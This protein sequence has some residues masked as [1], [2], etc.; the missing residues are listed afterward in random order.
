MEQKGTKRHKKGEGGVQMA[1]LAAPSKTAFCIE[2]KDAGILNQDNGAVLNA[3]QK[4]RKAEAS[5]ATPE[6]L[7]QLDAR[8]RTLEAKR[9]K[10]TR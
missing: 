9:G 6:R 10:A 1:L 5:S 7:R 4:I 2:E 3:F 8:I